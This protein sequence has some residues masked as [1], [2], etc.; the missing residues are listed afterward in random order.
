MTFPAKAIS[1]VVCVSDPDILVANLLAAL[2]SPRHAE[3]PI[4]QVVNLTPDAFAVNL[5]AINIVSC[6]GEMP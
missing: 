5:L 2:P 1:F 6:V 4:A 3:K